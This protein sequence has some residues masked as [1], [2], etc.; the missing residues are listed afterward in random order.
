MTKINPASA[1]NDQPQPQ[2]GSAGLLSNVTDKVSRTLH[3]KRAQDVNDGLAAERMIAFRRRLQ[4]AVVKGVDDTVAEELSA[5]LGLGQRI[6]ACG[7]VISGAAERLDFIFDC[8]LAEKPQLILARDERLRLQ[9]EVYRQ[10]GLITR[11]LAAIS[12]GSPVGLV[13]AALMFSLIIWTS[14]V[15]GV[16]WLVD[17]KNI[18]AGDIFFMNG[19]A[20]AAIAS[21]AFIG[22][23]ISIATRL[24]EFSRVRDLDPFAMFWTAMLKPLIGV[25]LSLFIFATIAGNIITFGFMENAELGKLLDSTVTIGNKA[26]YVFWVLG[27]LAGFSERFAWDFVDRAQGVANG[28]ADKKKPGN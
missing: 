28:G 7:T 11:A 1:A 17:S 18:L 20:L 5:A 26:L 15:F 24:Q 22:G 21:A 23:V 3:L 25:V 4:E 6:R 8:L 16:R 12:S 14:V 10:T 9:I 2:D 13:L 19:K 27:F